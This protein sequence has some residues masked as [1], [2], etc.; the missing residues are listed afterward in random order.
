[1]NEI[2]TRLIQIR[3]WMKL[4]NYDAF[5]IPHS[6]EY[7]SEYLPPQN[8]RL[9]WATGFNGSAGVAVITQDNAS[10][11]VDGRY[12]IQVREQVSDSLFEIK[13]LIDD[14]YLKWIESNIKLNSKIGYDAR[15]VTRNWLINANK[16][17]KNQFEFEA[18]NKNPIDLFWENRPCPDNPIA[19][20]LDEKYTG[21]SSL[22]KRSKIGKNLENQ[23][24]DGAFIT[25]LDSICWLLNIRGQ[26][27]PC[28]PVLLSH[29]LIY[30]NG[31]VD[32]FI[33]KNKIPMGFNEHI[34]L[35]VAVF[36]P[37]EL[38]IKLSNLNKLKMGYDMNR[39][40]A[41]SADIMENGG[42][43]VIN[44]QDP[45]IF[46]KACKNNIEAQ[47][48]RNSH[49]RDGVAVCKFLAWLDRQIE[50]NILLDE[51]ILSDKLELFRKEGDMF[52]G[53][54]F[55]TISGAGEN[56]AIVHYNHT[57]SNSPKKIEMN[58]VY[59]VDSGGQYLD[60]T[61]DI[62]R[63][64]I[65]GNPNTKI[66]KAFTLVLKGHIAL[67]RA[68]FP[69]GTAG[70]QLDP[71]ARQF[72]WENGMDYDHGTGH[73]VGHFLNVHEGPQGI[74]K[75]GSRVPLEA[76]M[77]ISNEPGYYET[78]EFGIRCENLVLV[79]SV[80]TSGNL[81][82]LEFE[83]LTMVPFDKN[84]LDLKLMSHSE[85]KWLNDYHQTVWD[86]ISQY[87]NGDDLKWLENQT[88]PIL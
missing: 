47:G 3:E 43:E 69:K 71:L 12:T 17:L 52:M 10:I 51:G 88:K 84:L 41:W 85:I 40:N 68:I 20:L 16:T 34:G 82:T 56:A 74:G 57:N 73:G 58:S 55:D 1:M 77:V 61:T 27:I 5:I 59:L 36:S 25:A 80:E 4:N 76:G 19:I 65:I 48:M 64:I 62:T 6:D 26:D 18:I 21:K 54:S 28:N 75:K 9:E 79:N 33:D 32:L 15:L 8:E 87:L 22:D 70:V 7:M 45:C 13:H 66:K 35:G 30:T 29:A 86:K 78:G 46:P 11:F 31:N 72:L 24:L 37:E 49:I 81:E 14:P 44:F 50:N 23:N 83:N 60:G 42:A 38:H 53:I 67:G 2:S 39:G 63:T